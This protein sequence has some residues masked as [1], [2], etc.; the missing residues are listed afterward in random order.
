MADESDSWSM[1]DAEDEASRD[2]TSRTSSSDL[3]TVEA[4]GD[5]FTC[6]VVYM[7]APEFCWL[8]YLD[9]SLLD[10]C[11]VSSKRFNF[12]TDCTNGLVHCI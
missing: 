12:S 6:Y 4:E 11:R 10:M 7:T 9:T 3:S 2:R 5:A 1:V 8:L